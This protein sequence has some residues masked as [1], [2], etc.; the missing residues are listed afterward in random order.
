MKNFR[1][2]VLL[3]FFFSL[4]LCLTSFKLLEADS[5]HVHVWGRTEGHTTENQH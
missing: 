3:K 5:F 4:L 1:V 2:K